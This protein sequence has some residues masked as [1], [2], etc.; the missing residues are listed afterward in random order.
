MKTYV[1]GDG[2]AAMMLA[3]KA[4]QLPD[5]DIAIVHPDDAPMSR[6]HM[7]GLSAVFAK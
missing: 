4:D 5:H 7:L 1:L 2:I 6:D 3:S